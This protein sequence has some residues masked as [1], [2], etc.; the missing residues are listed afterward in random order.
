MFGLDKLSLNDFDS[1]DH[2]IIVDALLKGLAQDEHETLHFVQQN[3]PESLAERLTQLCAPGMISGNNEE[4]LFEDLVRTLV[5]LR[6]IRVA[7][8]LNQ[9]KFILDDPEVAETGKNDL[10]KEVIKYTI[11]ISKLERALAKPSDKN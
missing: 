9:I 11:A 3:V 6:H 8:S 4:K 5:N 10:H 2:Q 7:S 1:S